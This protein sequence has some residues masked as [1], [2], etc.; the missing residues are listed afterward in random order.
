[1]V[2]ASCLHGTGWK[3]ASPFATGRD[4]VT[5]GPNDAAQRRFRARAVAPQIRGVPPRHPSR[6]TCSSFLINHPTWKILDLPQCNV[7]RTA[8]HLQSLQAESRLA[9]I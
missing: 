6:R 1:V 5:S 2:Q 8:A 9:G 3:P 7:P 4:I